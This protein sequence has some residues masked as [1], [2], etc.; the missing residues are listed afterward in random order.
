M[1]LS[2]SDIWLR[3]VASVL[4]TVICKIMEAT[5]PSEAFNLLSLPIYFHVISL[6]SLF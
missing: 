3:P 5:T 2:D 4:M 6:P 1:Q